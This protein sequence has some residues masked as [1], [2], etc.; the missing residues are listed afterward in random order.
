MGIGLTSLNFL[1]N[2][3]NTLGTQTN[4]PNSSYFWQQNGFHRLQMNGEEPENAKPIHVG[5]FISVLVDF[6]FQVIRYY[7]NDEL[8]GSIF[9]KKN[10]LKEGEIFPAANLSDKTEIVIM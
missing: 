1:K 5:D 6:D 7:K 9:C 3:G 10:K 2:N 4:G 8:A